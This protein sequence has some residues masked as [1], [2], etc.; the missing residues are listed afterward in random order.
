MKK[1]IEIGKEAY[2]KVPM[3]SSFIYYRVN[4]LKIFKN[5]KA[6]IEYRTGYGAGSLQK[7]NTPLSHLSPEFKSF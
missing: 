4:V 3:Y 6:R 1:K 5:G 7:T 2:W